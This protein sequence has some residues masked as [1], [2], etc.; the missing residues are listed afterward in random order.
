MELDRD[1]TIKET[2]KVFSGTPETIYKMLRQEA[3]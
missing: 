3:E 1:L 2:C